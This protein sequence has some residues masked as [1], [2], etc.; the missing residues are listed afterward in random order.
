MQKKA[1]GT[2]IL[3][4]VVAVW[5]P[6]QGN[7]V[8]ILTASSSAEGLDETAKTDRET[9]SG[10]GSFKSNSH[11]GGQSRGTESNGESLYPPV[12]YSGRFVAFYSLGSNLVPNDTNKSGDIFVH[13]QETKTTTRV[14]LS[15]S[16][17][18][19]N[20]NS[21][22]PSLSGDGRY[23]AFTSDSTN[24]VRNDKNN[25]ADVFIHDRN[26]RS[27]TRVSIGPKGRE[28]NG[29]SYTYVP[30]ISADGRFVTFASQATNLVPYDKNKAQDIFVHD[31]LTRQTRRVSVGRHGEEANGSSFHAVISGNGRYVAFH[32]SASNLVEGD[33]NGFSDV[34]IHDRS[35]SKTRRVSVGQ[36]GEQANGANDRVSISFKGDRVSFS[37]V[38]S[39]LV[40]DDKNGVE[41]VFLRDLLH[42]TTQR[43]SVG[44]IGRRALF[45]DIERALCCLL[46]TVCCIID[47]LDRKSVMSADGR[48]L[49][50][51][52]VSSDLVPDDK[53]HLVDVFVYSTDSKKT[54]RVSVDSRG[55]E[56]NG[57]SVHH[58]ISFDGRY[59]AFS[60]NASN[61]VENDTN[62]LSDIF[63]QDRKTG[64]TTRISVAS[65]SQ[66]KY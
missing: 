22:W 59:V 61:L 44:G 52:S 16:G 63:V 11:F 33:T 1:F 66:T 4:A 8:G 47:I 13:D 41:D 10:K 15:S 57:V 45:D 28:S 53:N 35:T 3:S 17:V 12:S 34:F 37:S 55:R 25:T 39:N 50:Y 30:S 7:A 20:K 48:N 38:A 62:G 36:H 24:L 2:L 60:S 58:G 6:F 27:T 56:G 14:S 40:P 49:V 29:L 5:S 51:R 18:E 54:T 42:G 23:V 43:V 21:I 32:S 65:E 46:S 31:R 26:T 19:G 64:Q 9:D